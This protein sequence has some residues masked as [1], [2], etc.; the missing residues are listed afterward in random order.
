MDVHQIKS[1]MKRVPQGSKVK[2]LQKIFRLQ[3]PELGILPIL[4]H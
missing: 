4:C 3:I 1:K 2:L